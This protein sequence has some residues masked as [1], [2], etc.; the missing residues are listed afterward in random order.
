MLNN[1]HKFYTYNEIQSMIEDLNFSKDK[2]EE[3]KQKYLL[4]Y[5]KLNKDYYDIL[6]CIKESSAESFDRFDSD[7]CEKFIKIYTKL[8]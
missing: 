5:G 3:F 6:Y 7:V 8:N 1:N 4:Y 2:K